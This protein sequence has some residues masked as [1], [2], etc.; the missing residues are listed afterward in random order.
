MVACRYT[1]KR[2]C[3]LWTTSEPPSQEA[4]QGHRMGA[5][6]QPNLGSFDLFETCTVAAPA[7]WLAGLALLLEWMSPRGRHLGRHSPPAAAAA[8]PSLTGLAVTAPRQSLLLCH[9]L[10]HDSQETPSRQGSASIST[11]ATVPMSLQ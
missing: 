2:A 5:W 7:N 1:N 10:S 8:A 11:D 3:V 9:A 4:V 6:P